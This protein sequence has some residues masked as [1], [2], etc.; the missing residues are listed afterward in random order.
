MAYTI[1]PYT[2]TIL[3]I[4]IAFSSS[5]LLASKEINLPAS[6]ISAAPAISPDSTSPLSSPSPALSPDISPLFPSLPAGPGL[7]PSESSMPLIPSSPSPP[8]PDAML[9]PGPA[10]AFGPSG[11]MPDSFSGRVNVPVFFRSVMV[12]FGAILVN[13]AL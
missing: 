3:A 9:A 12:V 13:A 1:S 5:S 4:F 10:M 11:P 6:T 2:V 8:N 7:S